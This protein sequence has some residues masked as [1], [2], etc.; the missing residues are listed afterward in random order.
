MCYF[1]SC[2]VLM[3]YQTLRAASTDRCQ[4][5]LQ[6]CAH[7]QAFPGKLLS[8]ERK[9]VLESSLRQ[10]HQE[11]TPSPVVVASSSIVSTQYDEQ[12]FF[13]DEL[14]FIRDYA[15]NDPISRWISVRNAP[16]LI[17]L[18]EEPRLV[19]VVINAQRS[20]GLPANYVTHSGVSSCPPTQARGDG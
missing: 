11:S 17:N 1:P 9:S 8:P 7:D 19:N 16:G 12:P 13:E 2:V 14:N 18:E 6:Q 4:R 5:S 10:A 15:D 20:F 3:C